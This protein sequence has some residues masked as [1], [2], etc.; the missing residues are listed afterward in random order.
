MV[1]SALSLPGRTLFAAIDDE[2]LAVRI[3]RHARRELLA[4]LDCGLLC[5]G[6]PD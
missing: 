1:R 2:A 4:Y 5:R 6:L 3:P